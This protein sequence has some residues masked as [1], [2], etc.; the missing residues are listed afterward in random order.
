M[1]AKPAY[2]VEDHIRLRRVGSIAASPDGRWLA[3]AVQRLDRDGVKYVSD[4]GSSP[5]MAPSRCS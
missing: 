5:P 2:D 1:T 4:L 3:V